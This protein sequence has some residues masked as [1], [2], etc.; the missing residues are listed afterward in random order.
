[1][2]ALGVGVAVVVSSISTIYFIYKSVFHAVK[3]VVDD[4]YEVIGEDE[5]FLD[6]DCYDERVE[7]QPSGRMT[8][9]LA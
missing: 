7:A 2:A 6:I 5:H 4:W 8:A 9:Q 3:S 1:M